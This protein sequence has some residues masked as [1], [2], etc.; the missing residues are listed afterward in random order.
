MHKLVT[1]GVVFAACRNAINMHSLDE[2]S[3]PSFVRVVPACKTEIAKKQSQGY[4][5][6][7]P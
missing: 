1:M 6:I 5:Y 3:L 7:K 2:K 4:A